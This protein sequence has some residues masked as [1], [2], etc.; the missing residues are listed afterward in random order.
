MRGNMNEWIILLLAVIK[1]SKH[2]KSLCIN[3]KE[4]GR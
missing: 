4:M 2:N 3:G 1:L